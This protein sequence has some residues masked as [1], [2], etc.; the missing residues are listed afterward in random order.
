MTRLTAALLLALVAG[1]A[2]AQDPLDA[3]PAAAPPAGHTP[4]PDPL[5]A[6]PRAPAP[7]PPPPPTAATRWRASAL[8]ALGT[9]FE[10]EPAGLNPLGFGLGLHADY[11]WLQHW[12][13][14]GRAVFYL[15][16]ST[17]LATGRF[18]MSSWLVAAE[19]ARAWPLGPCTLEPNLALGL[20]IR[21]AD[22]PPAAI[23]TAT[24]LVV[25]GTRSATHPGLYVSPGVLL[26]LPLGARLYV[27]LETRLDLTFGRSVDSGIQGLLQLG[28]RL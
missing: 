4:R 8:L 27:A 13:V 24:P 12:H 10:R 22:G 2:H 6:F 3:F 18:A 21:D 9:H 7:T 16:D 15:G 17:Q 1:S 25:P 11:R 26:A 20:R 19:L 23:T 14:G 5:H 28:V